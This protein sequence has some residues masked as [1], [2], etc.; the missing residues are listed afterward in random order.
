MGTNISTNEPDP[1]ALDVGPIGANYVEQI[2]WREASTGKLLAASDFF[3]PMIVGMQVWA[4]Y[5]GFI[6]EGLNDRAFNGIEGVTTNHKFK[7]DICFDN[8]ESHFNITL[9]QNYS[10]SVSSLLNPSNTGLILF[11]NI[12]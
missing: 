7:W 10:Q 4:G 5:G 2:Q 6:Y 8:K 1:A 9:G 11:V 12:S 3:S